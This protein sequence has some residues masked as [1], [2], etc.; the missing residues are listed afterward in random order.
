[1]NVLVIGSGGREHALAWKLAHSPSVTKV[2][3][4]PGNP[5]MA[6]WAE[7]HAGDPLETAVRNEA[8]FVIV[9]PELPLVGGIVD[10]FRAAGIPVLGPTQAAAEIEGSKI[11]AKELMSE[12]GIPTARYTV[13]SSL[14]EAHRALVRFEYPVVLKADGLAAG[15]GVVV[16]RNREEAERGLAALFSGELAG[17]AGRRI[18][19]EDFL[20]G[21]EVSFIVLTDGRTIVPFPPAQDHKAV[22]DG[23]QG[24]NTGG[25][26][27]YCDDAILTAAEREEILRTVIRPAVDTLAAR[28][29]PFTGFLFAGLM[30]T[31]EGIRVLEFN[32]RLGDPE[33]Q[34]MLARIEGDFG[35]LCLAAAEGR[36]DSVSVNWKPDPSVCVVLASH[37]Y[38]VSPRTGDLITGIEAAEAEGTIV[39][40]AGTRLGAQGLETAGGRV[41]GVT[42]TAPNLR[43]AIETAYRGVARI[44][45]E[46]MHCRRDIG[47]KGLR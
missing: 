22:Y 21:V 20:P 24:P 23:D 11:F 40:Q 30:K 13:A 15:K 8:N 46:G 19:I 14:V 36:L 5:G 38:P 39:F 31:R 17:D 3:A 35:A 7:C 10:R 45:F 6:K 37:G 18:V 25:M 12:A 9:G 2:W 44:R 32:A 33:C 34:T 4:T 27:A 43:A 28:G 42:A 41:L 1:M 47:Q 16:A 26:G 29:T